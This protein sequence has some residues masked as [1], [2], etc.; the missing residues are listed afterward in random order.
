MR[1]RGECEV[2]GTIGGSRADK[3]GG[4]TGREECE[5]SG[6]IKRGGGQTRKCANRGAAV[7][8]TGREKKV[9]RV[10]IEGREKKNNFEWE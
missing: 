1:R 5:V 3:E 8:T 10:N 6:A 7:M 9:R 4:E 2:S